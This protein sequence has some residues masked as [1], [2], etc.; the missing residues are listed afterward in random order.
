VDLGEEVARTGQQRPRV[1]AQIAEVDQERLL[2]ILPKD[3]LGAPEFLRVRRLRR[4]LRR[5]ERRLEVVRIEA[6]K[7]DVEA[8][9]QG[10][11]ARKDLDLTA[12]GFRRRVKAHRAA[13]DQHGGGRALVDVGDVHGALGEREVEV[14]SGDPQIAGRKHFRR[15]E[16]ETIEVLDRRQPLF[17][18]DGPFL[19]AAA[20]AD[21]FDVQPPGGGARARAELGED[22]DH[23]SEAVAGER[24]AQRFAIALF[25]HR[26][27]RTRK[28]LRA[29]EVDRPL[30]VGARRQQ[31]EV[32]GGITRF[33]DLL[34]PREQRSHGVA[35]LCV[36]A[37]AHGHRQREH[38]EERT[39]GHSHES[40]PELLF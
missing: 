10:F 19:G 35:L 30:T 32:S 6:D 13:S 18:I 2:R 8:R 3:F 38:H 21:A 33:R 31:R 16:C 40:L 37:G 5:G 36:P 15:V 9:L 24:A 26:P 34:D 39:I 14:L 7:C 4:Q 12:F 29:A 27:R 1:A 11:A 17:V 20:L 22:V 28:Q 23:Q 25:H